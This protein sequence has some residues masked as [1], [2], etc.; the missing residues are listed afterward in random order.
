MIDE[1]TK[2]H[3]VFSINGNSI[4][5]W[6]FT[7]K[8][9]FERP[10]LSTRILEALGPELLLT[11]LSDSCRGVEAARL[12][13]I[14]T[15]GCDVEP[16]NAPFFRGPLHKALEYGCTS[17]QVI[18][19]FHPESLDR[20]W[21]ELPASLPCEEREQIEALYPSVIP[22]VDGSHLWFTRFHSDDM[23]AG[24]DYERQYGAWLP[25]DPGKALAALIIITEDPA[26]LAKGL[27]VTTS[28]EAAKLSSTS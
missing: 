20:S 2:P 4:P 12:P 26:M 18:Q 19:V 17:D 14:L 25:G 15:T 5:V 27:L 3:Q 16:S 24:T 13:V 23:R 10:R 21:R 1:I 6:V 11:I 28:L 22:S 7:A 8:A 9:G